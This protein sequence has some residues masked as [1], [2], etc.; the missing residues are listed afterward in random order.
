MLVGSLG[1]VMQESTLIAYTVAKRM[2]RQVC[3][4]S[5][6]LK[7]QLNADRGDFFS[8]HRVHLHCPAGGRPKEG[9]SAGIGITTSLLSLALN[10]PLRKDLSMTGEITLTGRVLPIGGLLYV[11]SYMPMQTL[12]LR[13]NELQMNCAAKE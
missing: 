6:S 10:R 8:K 4:Q 5:A 13:T 12:I 1:A 2:L 11:H 9:P 3:L 7:F